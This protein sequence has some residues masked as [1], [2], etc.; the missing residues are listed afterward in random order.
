MVGK[1]IMGYQGKVYI[2]TRSHKDTRKIEV[3]Q[4][5]QKPQLPNNQK[6]FYKLIQF[7]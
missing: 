5:K 3:L 7:H 6:A 2:K 1:H 4:A